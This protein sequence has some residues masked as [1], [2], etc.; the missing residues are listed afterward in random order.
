[1]QRLRTPC[2]ATGAEV[3][4]T[5]CTLAMPWRELGTAALLSQPT[6]RGPCAVRSRRKGGMAQNASCSARLG[7]TC[8]PRSALFDTCAILFTVGNEWKL[9]EGLNKSR[10]Q[11]RAFARSSVHGIGA[12]A[13]T[14]GVVT[15]WTHGRYKF[16]SPLL[17]L[18]HERPGL[19]ERRPKRARLSQKRTIVG[20]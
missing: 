7:A 3:D 17:A 9:A 2:L 4:V 19:A 13:K 20:S 16:F 10:R 8:C 1:M 5:G 11:T 14:H 6:Q 15:T 18:Q 12:S